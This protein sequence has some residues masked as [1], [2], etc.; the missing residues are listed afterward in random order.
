MGTYGYL[1]EGN[2]LQKTNPTLSQSTEVG[3]GASHPIL[4][5]KLITETSP[6]GLSMLQGTRYIVTN[7]NETY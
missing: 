5:K 2:S 3:H 7:V 4:W 1:S 6:T